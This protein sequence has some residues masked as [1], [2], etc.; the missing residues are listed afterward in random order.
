MNTPTRSNT[1]DPSLNWNALS[2]YS[3]VATTDAKEKKINATTLLIRVDGSSHKAI[4]LVQ[5]TVVTFKREKTKGGEFTNNISRKKHGTLSSSTAGHLLLNNSK[6]S[7]CINMRDI[8]HPGS[9]ST[10]QNGD[11]FSILD[12][13]NGRLMYTLQNSHAVVVLQ[14]G[15]DTVQLKMGIPKTIACASVLNQQACSFTLVQEVPACVRVD[16]LDADTLNLN[17]HRKTSS[18]VE[19]M[20]RSFFIR[21]GDAILPQSDGG[22]TSLNSN[23]SISIQPKQK[24]T[25]KR[26]NGNLTHQKQKKSKVDVSKSKDP[27]RGDNFERNV[28]VSIVEKQPKQQQQQNILQAKSLFPKEC[29]RCGEKFVS[30]SSSSS[31]S[32]RNATLDEIQDLLFICNTCL[33]DNNTSTSSSQEELLQKKINTKI[34]IRNVAL[35]LQRLGSPSTLAGKFRT[36]SEDLE[37]ANKKKPSR[38][39]NLIIDHL[40]N[41]ENMEDMEV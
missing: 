3:V 12:V 17:L 5:G 26:H 10:I 16:A 8:L 15:T 6:D 35:Q 38:V 28:V 27:F 34:N 31:S 18:R 39:T 11:C 22:I 1:N 23:F 2:D 36:L 21:E 32:S 19:A 7:M 29:N 13:D 14:V 20:Q 33:D 4:H 37:R 40:E 30:S 41:D 9:S 24:R 25:N